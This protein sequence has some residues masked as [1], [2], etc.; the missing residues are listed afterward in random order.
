MNNY[1]TQMDKQ[2]NMLNEIAAN[3]QLL[4][5]QLQTF[6]GTPIN[7]IP[8]QQMPQ[9]IPQPM[10][11]QMQQP[12]NQQMPQQMN[13]QMPQ[14]MQQQMPQQIQQPMHQPVA[15]ARQINYQQPNQLYQQP[16][17]QQYVNQT[18]SQPQQIPN[19]NDEIELSEVRDSTARESALQVRDVPQNQPPQIQPSQQSQQINNQIQQLI[20]N[21][22]DAVV[23]CQNPAVLKKNALQKKPVRPLPIKK[24]PESKVFLEYLIIPI[25]LILI[26][27][28]LVHPTTS[29]ML[30]RFLPDMKNLQ[31]MFNRGLILVIL[32]LI[33]R[34]MTNPLL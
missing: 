19:D 32:Y 5:Q 18:Y 33:I 7:K 23:K 30:E 21:G 12:M 11:Q 31:G 25:V 10:Q 4:Q 16:N 3:N 1:H 2:P 28:G 34:L 26:F 14:P 9:Q 17:N 15:N 22:D 24:E 8:Q 6:Q 27:V 20:Q 29:K 13:Q